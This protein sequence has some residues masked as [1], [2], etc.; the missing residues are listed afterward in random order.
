MVV[1]DDHGG[2]T[3]PHTATRPSSFCGG[4]RTAA[5][6][7]YYRARY[8][9]ALGGNQDRRAACRPNTTMQYKR[10]RSKRNRSLQ[11]ILAAY[12]ALDSR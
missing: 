3:R 2:I 6:V 8:R 10:V 12:M 7:H 1:A 11:L 9:F 4:F 5:H